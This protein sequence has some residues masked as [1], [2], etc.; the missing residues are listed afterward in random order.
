MS[1]Y[2]DPAPPPPEEESAL[3]R[4]RRRARRRALRYTVFFAVANITVAIAYATAG[5]WGLTL[6]HGTTAATHIFIYRV[7]GALWPPTKKPRS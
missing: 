7:L 2:R 6:A 5:R 1:G 4:L 3:Q